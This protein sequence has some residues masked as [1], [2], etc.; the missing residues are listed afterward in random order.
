M[1]KS[2][3]CT[4]S[5]TQRFHFQKSGVQLCT[6]ICEMTWVAFFFFHMN[7][8][9]LAVPASGTDATGRVFP[10]PGTKTQNQRGPAVNTSPRDVAKRENRRK[11]KR[12]RIS[13][14]AG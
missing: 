4:N 2:A 5:S 7:D 14:A 10:G 1:A 8:K 9:A 11:S 12:E 3:T 13:G 6:H